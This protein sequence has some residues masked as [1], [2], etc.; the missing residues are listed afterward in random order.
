MA[1]HKKTKNNSQDIPFTKMITDLPAIL[2][3]RFVKHIMVALLMIAVTVFLIIYFNS[4]SYCIGLLIAVY[5]AYLGF[6]TV[7]AYQ[8]GKLICKTMICIKANKLL[9][10]DRL[11]AIMRETGS[12]L[13]P[14][15]I[16]HQFYISGSKR[17]LEL[18]TPNT[19]LNVYY[20]PKNTLEITAWE[21]IDYVGNA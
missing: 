5:I 10:Q 4:W 19:V 13:P 9:K 11:Y 21:I 16:T 3:A 7:W 1:N 6:D 12:E 17:D 14:E 20:R 8:S 18:I 15:K 2:Q